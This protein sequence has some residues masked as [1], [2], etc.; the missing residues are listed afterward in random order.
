MSAQLIHLV[1]PM[2]EADYRRPPLR[3]I[4]RR[5][6]ALQRGFG[7][8]RRVAI[9]HAALDYDSFQGLHRERLLCLV[10]GGLNQFKKDKS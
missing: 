2:A 4:T 3:W 1:V 10:Q 5:A 8:S 7:I 6:R 9:Y